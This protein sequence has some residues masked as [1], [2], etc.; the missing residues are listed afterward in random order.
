M[1]EAF[2]EYGLLV[3]PAQY[4]TVETQATFAKRFGPSRVRIGP[5]H[6]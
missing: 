4:L 3:F 2:N 5:Q 1:E 6:F